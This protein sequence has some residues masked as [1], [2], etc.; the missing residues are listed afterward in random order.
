MYRTL[1]RGCLTR[2]SAPGVRRF[3]AMLIISRRFESPPAQVLAIVMF[4]A[5]LGCTIDRRGL[6]LAE[7][8][9]GSGGSVDAAPDNR[10]TPGSGGSAG[11]DSSQGGAAGRGGTAGQGG[12]TPPDASAGG[13]GSG[14]VGGAAG[15]AGAEAGVGGEA[16]NVVPPAAL[17][18]GPA[19]KDFGLVPTG[20]GASQIFTVTNTGSVSTGTITAAL[21]GADSTNF[22]V[23][24][25]TCTGNLGPGATCNL[26]V[27]FSPATPLG[28][29]TATL[30]ARANPGGEALAALSGTATTP[31]ALAFSPSAKDFTT[32]D[33]NTSTTASTF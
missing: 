22:L 25:N 30:S 33:I 1:W 26:T 12:S 2:G 17:A 21:S 19:T 8:S 14:G 9:G 15:A 6:S 32:I 4:A 31:V 13:G 20:N 29:K 24:A 11:R 28:G 5:F 10:G 7:G 16:G 27:N 3:L 18:L 23:T